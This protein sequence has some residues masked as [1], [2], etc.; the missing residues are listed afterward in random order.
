MS[1]LTKYGLCA[2]L[3]CGLAG[4]V[5]SD[6]DNTNVFYEK[7]NLESVVRANDSASKEKE[8]KKTDIIDVKR[9]FLGDFYENKVSL[10]LGLISLSAN[11]SNFSVDLLNKPASFNL[12]SYRDESKPVSYSYPGVKSDDLWFNRNY[13]DADEPIPLSAL[14]K[15]AKDL[16]WPTDVAKPVRYLSDK[17]SEG[18]SGIS[19]VPTKFIFGEQAK[20]DMSFKVDSKRLGVFYKA[21]LNHRWD[22]TIDYQYCFERDSFTGEK[23]KT[24]FV[25]FGV[26]FGRGR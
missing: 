17:F 14:G 13:E 21:Q 9:E 26:S 12:Y 22:L 11:N 10:D 3:S 18:V 8:Q 19:D 24:L 25:S 4:C 2:V 15:L 6:P 20:S 1:T 5:Y 23:E 16:I 7:Y